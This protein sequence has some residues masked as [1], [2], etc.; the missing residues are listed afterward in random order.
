MHLALAMMWLLQADPQALGPRALK[1]MYTLVDGKD[2]ECTQV[3]ADLA[4]EL[5]EKG[6]CF[7]AGYRAVRCDGK[8]HRLMFRTRYQCELE[9]KKR[10]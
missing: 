1:G 2:E 10:W 3:D 6:Q 5:A 7:Q 9:Q 4:N 8:P